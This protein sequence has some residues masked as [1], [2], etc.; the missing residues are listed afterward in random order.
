[1]LKKALFVAAAFFMLSAVAQATNNL[2]SLH[3]S[4]G[5]GKTMSIGL[6]LSPTGAWYL[7]SN[8]NSSAASASLLGSSLVI[9]G[10]SAGATTVLVCGDIQSSQCL[11]V[12]VTVSNVLGVSIAAHAPG[13]WL[14]QGKTVYYVTSG[15][16]VPVPTWKI[17]LSNGG[18]SSLLQSAN[19]ADLNLPM[20]P[21]MIAHDSRV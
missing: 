1:M 6:N 12:A 21:L 19:S 10:L 5:V 20:L 13:A 8:S 18:K 11:S 17:F 4:I 2:G 15:G 9:K 7:T 16:L 3:Q 14:V